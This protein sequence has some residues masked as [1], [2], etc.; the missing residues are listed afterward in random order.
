[1]EQGG[2]AGGGQDLAIDAVVLAERLDDLELQAVLEGER[3]VTDRL[4]GRAG[5][6]DGVAHLHVTADAVDPAELAHRAVDVGRD[7]GQLVVI[8]AQL[9]AFPP[10]SGADPEAVF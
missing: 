3:E 7:I 10:A 8:A 5:G 2:V 9:D 1:M 4:A 6:E